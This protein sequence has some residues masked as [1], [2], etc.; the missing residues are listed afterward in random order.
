MKR[1]FLAILPFMVFVFCRPAFAYNSIWYDVSAG[2]PKMKKIVVLAMEGET[3]YPAAEE[4][5]VHRL[6]NKVKGIHFSL[7]KPHGDLAG[8]I[9]AERAYDKEL[10]KKFPSEEKRAAA[11]YDNT[12]ADAY[13]VC[14]IRENRV[15]TDRSPRTEVEVTMRRY[16]KEF[17]ERGKWW[18]PDRELRTYNQQEWTQHHVIPEQYVHLRR[19]TLEYTLYD[20]RGK[21]ILT[22][23]DRKYS[24]VYNEKELF[25]DSLKEM[26]EEMRDIKKGKRK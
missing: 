23:K 6:E 25:E 2:I 14:A 15:Q 10:L 3:G 19:I 9:L 8:R 18:Q 21:K 12:G 11:V 17:E 4:Y 1:A 22:M 7:V 20:I 16:T 5:L 24:Y 26:A 13:L